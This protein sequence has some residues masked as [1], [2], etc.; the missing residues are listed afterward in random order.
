MTEL[1]QEVSSS[2]GHGADERPT[3]FTL[4]ERTCQVRELLGSRQGGDHTCFKFIADETNLHVIRHD[5]DADIRELTMTETSRP[6]ARHGT[7]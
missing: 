5:R 3:S 4:G 1:S 6:A 2:S 7:N